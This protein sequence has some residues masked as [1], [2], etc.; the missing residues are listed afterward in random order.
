MSTFTLGLNFFL[1]R[2]IRVLSSAEVSRD[3]LLV[4]MLNAGVHITFHKT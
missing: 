4:A 2:G 1:I 3:T